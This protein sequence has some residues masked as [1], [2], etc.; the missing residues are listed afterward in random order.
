MNL[1]EQQKNRGFWLLFFALF[2]D[3]LGF[4][5]MIPLLPFYAESLGANAFVVALTMAVYSLGQFLFAPLW[6]RLSDRFGRRPIILV[7]LIGTSISFVLFGFAST[8]FLLF[9]SRILGGILTAATLPTSQAYVAD[10]TSEKERAKKFGM[11]GA[12]FGLGFIFGPAIGGLLSVYGYAVPAFFAAALAFLNFLG[13]Y[14][15]LPETYKPAPTEIKNYHL[16]DV[17]GMWK[18]ITHEHI[19]ALVIISAL[20]ALGFSQLQGMYALFAEQRFGL[21]PTSVGFVLFVVGIVS[22]VVQ[23]A[24]VGKVVAWIG[25]IKTVILGTLILGLSYTLIGLS[26]NTTMLY[27]F[28][29][30]NAAGF[31]LSGPSLNALISGRAHKD[32]QGTILGLSQSWAAFSRVIGP[33]FAGI[34]FGFGLALPFYMGAFFMLCAMLIAVRNYSFYAK[35]ISQQ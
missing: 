5:I 15:W 34:L 30:I 29:G 17:R 6:G 23:G 19:G 27:I 32:E 14:F 11:L 21:G 18:S 20:I 25:E 16:V 2:I 35:D 7:G 12:A 4:G 28:T 1:T 22:V 9:V 13:A 3:L 31:A 26:Y 24:V 10:M 8:L 33:P